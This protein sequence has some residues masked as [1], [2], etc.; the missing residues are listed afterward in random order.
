MNPL[1]AAILATFATNGPIQAFFP[2]WTPPNGLVSQQVIFRDYAPEGAPLPFVVVSTVS[3]VPVL[4]YGNQ[5][6]GTNFD[7]FNLRF[8]V[9][10]TSTATVSAPAAAGNGMDLVM[11]AFDGVTLSLSSGTN[12]TTIRR[13]SPLLRYD[14]KNP[15]GEEVWQCTAVLEY[16]IQP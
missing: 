12:F 9:F 6:A 7:V 4:Q 1:Y 5:P 8:S 15:S 2:P 16:R 14:S 13:Q 10:A 11:S 3:A